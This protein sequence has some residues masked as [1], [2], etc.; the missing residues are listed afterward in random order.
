MNICPAADQT[1]KESGGTYRKIDYNLSTPD[2]VYVLPQALNEISGI[3]EVDESSIACVQ[4]ENGIIFIYNIKKNEITRQFYFASAGDYEDLARVD[5]NLFVLRSDEVLNEII[6]F[7]SDKVRTVSYSTG[8]PGK[9]NEGLCY[10][11]KNNR[12]LIVPKETSDD[13]DHKGKRSIYGFDLASKKIIKGPAFRFDLSTIEKFAL[14]NKL[15]VPMKNKKKGEKGEP[16]IKFRISALAIHPI[17]NKLFL[18]SGMEKLLFVFDMNGNIEY[19]E[20]LNPD[21]FAQPEGI[22]FM[23]NGDM[24]ISNEARNELPTLVRYNFKP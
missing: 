1:G 22:T 13:P 24:Y 21:L 11:K 7:K 8:I 20:K 9:D 14:E 6:D 18:I 12:L 2:N 5:K 10:D 19:L 16:D 23:N 4:D 17:L 15:K 3:T